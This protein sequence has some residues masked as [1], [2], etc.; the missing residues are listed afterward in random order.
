MINGKMWLVVKPSVG[1]P[2]FFGA[3][4]GVSLAIHAVVL[5]HTTWYPAFLQGGKGGKAAIV[6][7]V[8]TAPPSISVAAK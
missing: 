2:L 1:L 5:T 6:S 7:E 3:I 4:V 8:D